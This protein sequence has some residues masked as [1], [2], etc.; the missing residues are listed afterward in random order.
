MT[1]SI[2]SPFTKT[3]LG[4][5]QGVLMQQLDMVK[6]HHAGEPRVA[7]AVTAAEAAINGAIAALLAL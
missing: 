4:M 6:A 2:F 7:D 1:V 5:A 3:L